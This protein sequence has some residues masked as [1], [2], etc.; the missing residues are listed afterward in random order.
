MKVDTRR[1]S[2]GLA[3]DKSSLD[4]VVEG[5]CGINVEMHTWRTRRSASDISQ[6]S[7]GT[8]HKQEVWPT[9]T[10]P[11]PLCTRSTAEKA[12]WFLGRRRLSAIRLTGWMS[13]NGE[14]PDERVGL[15]P[16]HTHT[17]AAIYATK[18]RRNGQDY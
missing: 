9:T 15:R 10:R 1:K 13:G 3:Q 8:Q 12:V 6:S 4:D 14:R 7:A 2:T 18:Q 11:L 5:Q 16:R 17:D